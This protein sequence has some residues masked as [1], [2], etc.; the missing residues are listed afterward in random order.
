MNRMCL[1]AIGTILITAS[2]AVAQQ[3]TTTSAE[4]THA[5]STGQLAVPAPETQLKI[6]IEKLDL[7][8]DQQAKI[9][10]ILQDLHDATLKIV[11][12]KTLSHEERLA[13]V[14]PHRFAADKRIRDILNEEQKKKLDAYEQGPHPE[15]HGDLS[16]ETAPQHPQ[17]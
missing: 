11:Q 6:L 12:D 14:R 3:P 17:H 15:M 2:T 4:S 8:S 5:S 16:G 7:T 9:R 13:R 1:L 10:P